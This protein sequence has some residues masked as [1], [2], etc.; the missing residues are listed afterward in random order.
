ML[1]KP[2]ICLGLDEIGLDRAEELIF[3]LRDNISAIKCNLAFWAIRPQVLKQV[4]RFANSL[5]VKTIIDG[6]F[7]DIEYSMKQYAKFAYEELGADSCTVNITT[8]GGE[9]LRYFIDY[10]NKLTFV[11]ARP[12]QKESILRDEKGPLNSILGKCDRYNQNGNLGL[13]L[14]PDSEEAVINGFKNNALLV[15]GIG[16]QGYQIK[17]VKLPIKNCLFNV[18]RSIIESENPKEL[19]ENLLR[20]IT[21]AVNEKKDQNHRTV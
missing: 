1:I 10:E 11:L 16:K 6:K 14:S 19:I 5:G 17:D 4:F 18:G 9:G 13:V 21:E 12:T 8:C 15:P 3:E 2:G 7:N 20:E